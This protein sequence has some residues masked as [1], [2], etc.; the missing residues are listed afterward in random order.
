MTE[1][2]LVDRFYLLSQSSRFKKASPC[3]L[4]NNNNHIISP[5]KENVKDLIKCVP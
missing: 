5:K 3:I 1:W 2:L 4:S